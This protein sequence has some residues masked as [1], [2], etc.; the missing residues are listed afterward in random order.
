[1]MPCLFGHARSLLQL[2]N[3]QTDALLDGA[4]YARVKS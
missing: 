2:L 1:M 4:G 3:Q